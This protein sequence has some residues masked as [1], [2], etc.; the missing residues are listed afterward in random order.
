MG[1][2]GRID[3]SAAPSGFGRGRTPTGAGVGGPAIVTPARRNGDRGNRVAP[4][5]PG[6][7]PGKTTSL[8]ATTLPSKA[9]RAEAGSKGTNPRRAPTDNPPVVESET[10]PGRVP[11]GD[12]SPWG[13]ATKIPRAGF[14][15][16]GSISSMVAAI[17]RPADFFAGYGDCPNRFPGPPPVKGATGDRPSIPKRPGAFATPDLRIRG[18]RGL[19]VRRMPSFPVSGGAVR[20]ATWG[21]P[22][23]RE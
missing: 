2:L 14:F 9:N 5:P 4:P 21:R 18:A 16:S 22:G 15:N 10:A 13:R 23:V 3:I 7:K 11:D 17:S 19:P 6:W 20:K 12:Q 8:Q 1:N